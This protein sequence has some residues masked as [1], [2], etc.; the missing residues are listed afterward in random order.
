MAPDV[1]PMSYPNRQPP[2]AGKKKLHE[3][4]EREGSRYKGKE[5]E[6]S[7]PSAPRCDHST[8]WSPQHVP[9]REAESG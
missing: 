8:L 5:G 3:A 7:T 6:Q 9:K 2:S 4:K 1:A